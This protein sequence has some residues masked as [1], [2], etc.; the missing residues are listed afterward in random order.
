MRLLAFIDELFQ[1][2]D[3]RHLSSFTATCFV[4]RL[5]SH[6]DHVSVLA[7]CEP[8]G[9][10]QG[11]A[12]VDAEALG[13]LLI[14]LPAWSTMIQFI[15]RL[16]SMGGTLHKTAKRHVANCDVVWLRVPSLGA[17]FFYLAARRLGRPVLL[18][19]MS[20]P[21]AAW[22][23]SRYRGW[24]RP[25]AWAGAQ[26]VHAITR[27]MAR[28]S[29]VLA[30]GDHLL[31]AYGRGRPSML[32]V[33]AVISEIPAKPRPGS[34]EGDFQFLYVG[35]L[36]E[37][38][39]L[40][41][42]FQALKGLSPSKV[43][44]NVTVRIVGTGP[45]EAILREKAVEAGVSDRVQFCGFVGPGPKLDQI[46]IQADALVVPTSTYPEGVPRVILEAWTMGLPVVCTRVGGIPG[47]VND[48]NGLLADPGQVMDLEESMRRL[49]TDPVLFADLS[50]GAV[51]S[52]LRFAP[53]QQ[54]DAIL[55]LLRQHNQAVNSRKSSFADG[56][57]LA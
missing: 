21:L 6:F 19:V 35:R 18:H 15:R 27:W 49:S 50:R 46:Y 54:I 12:A 16:F 34:S 48:S 41:V 13:V 3:G 42:L 17:V 9:N 32:F 43:G 7:P 8:V 51:A 47:V 14:E 29:I 36:L 22:K 11:T 4:A 25:F 28:N 31:K 23:D 20:D 1:V 24:A 26:V 53:N 38:K 30:T 2:V 45:D 5:R 33:D 44:R 56:G 39:G 57:P 55:G 10:P 37:S 52:A 40:D